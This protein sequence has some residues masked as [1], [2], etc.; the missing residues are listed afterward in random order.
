MPQDHA[1]LTA[2]NRAVMQQFIALFYEARDVRGAFERHVAADYIQHNPA[3]GDGRDAAIAALGPKFGQPGSSF[4]V[5]RL[6]V[7]GEHAAVHLH[8]RPDPATNGVAV[9]DIYRLEN[10]WI[11]EHWDVLQPITPHPAHPHPYF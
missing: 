4:A 8:G 9:A 1:T 3:I 2:A 6:I 5:K 7:D 11:V 10:G